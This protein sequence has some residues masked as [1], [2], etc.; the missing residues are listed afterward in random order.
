MRKWNLTLYPIL[1][2]HKGNFTIKEWMTPPYLNSLSMVGISLMARGEDS[3]LVDSGASMHIRNTIQGFH[4]TR[5]L[6]GGDTHIYTHSYAKASIGVV[7]D[8][9][10]N[11]PA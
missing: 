10:I 2:Q 4:Q 1:I 5:C 9:V 6:S 8:V 3:R 11:L 7:I